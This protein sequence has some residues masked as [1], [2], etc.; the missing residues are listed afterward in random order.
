MARAIQSLKVER[1]SVSLI[2]LFP[3]GRLGES[4]YVKQRISPDR[5]ALDGPGAIKVSGR[6]DWANENGCS[7]VNS[8]CAKSSC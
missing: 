6:L 5:M 2:Q 7:K 1:L 4:S 8:R 3:S